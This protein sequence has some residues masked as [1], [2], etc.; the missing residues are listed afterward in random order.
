MVKAIILAI[1]GLSGHT[2]WFNPLKDEFI[3]YD[4]DFHAIDLPGF[5][6]NHNQANPS[7]PYLIGHIDAY[8]DWIK[9]CQSKYQELKS[10][11]PNSIICV[12]G[13]SL[14]AVVA[15]HLKLEVND[16][17]ILSVPAFK[18]AKATFNPVFTI[19]TLTKVIIG[20]W[21]FGKDI[22]ITLPVSQ[23]SLD[24]PAMKDPLRVGVVTQTLLFEI[25]K[26]QANARK[27]IS[28]INSKLLMIQ[29]EDDKVVDNATQDLVFDEIVSSKKIKKTYS[30]VD[31]DWIWYDINAVITKDIAEWL[32]PV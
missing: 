32:D 19:L 1:H 30:G 31:H 22:Y 12:M 10:K 26:M 16:K 28:K 4:I 2:G 8:L 15:C 13:H 11:N 23:K 24:S 7:N 29:I 27:I 14:G 6:L 18:G 5:G 21:I 25:L 20:K 3:K 9:Y 17:L